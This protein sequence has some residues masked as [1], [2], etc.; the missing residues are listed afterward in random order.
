MAKFFAI[1]LVIIAIA[2]AVPVVLH[3]WTPPE[4]I[5]THGHLIDKHAELGA[6]I[7]KQA[8]ERDGIRSAG[9][10]NADTITGGQHPG[11]TDGI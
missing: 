4:D 9:D 11:L 3:T 8:K 5:S 10:G 1:T 2:S 7:F 6:K